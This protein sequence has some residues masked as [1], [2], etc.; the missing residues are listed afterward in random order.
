[1]E[2]LD[3][4][5]G[6]GVGG[7]N[8]AESDNEES[9][10]DEEEE[11]EEIPLTAV[12]HMVAGLTKVLLTVCRVTI[13]LWDAI[14]MR[15]VLPII[16]II[17]HAMNKPLVDPITALIIVALATIIIIIHISSA[18]FILKLVDASIVFITTGSS[19]ALSSVKTT[20][21]NTYGFAARMVRSKDSLDDLMKRVHLGQLLAESYHGKVV[22][23]ATLAT[24]GLA[25]HLHEVCC[26]G[27][28]S[29]TGSRLMT[30]LAAQTLRVCDLN[31][32]LISSGLIVSPRIAV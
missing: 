21:S 8:G 13:L 6:G 7:G 11:V 4:A 20:A 19:L 27:V 26:N 30:S 31:A 15:T 2:A 1:M 3:N 14:A 29:R 28:A 16:D 18:V 24:T 5:E 9:E 17:K 23:V 10:I 32:N 25:S 12:E 22:D